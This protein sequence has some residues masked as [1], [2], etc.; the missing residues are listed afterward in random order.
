MPARYVSAACAT[1][2]D[3]SWLQT[4]DRDGGTEVPPY[5]LR[6]SAPRHPGTPAPG[7]RHP[8]T[9]HPAPGTYSSFVIRNS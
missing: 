2:F 8:S 6:P 4:L 5:V 9:R 3:D 7:T 1:A